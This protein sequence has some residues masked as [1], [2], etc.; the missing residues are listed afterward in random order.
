MRQYEEGFCLTARWARQPHQSL[1]HV[2]PCDMD[3]AEAM[4]IFFFKQKTAYGRR[5]SDWSSDVCSS[6]LMPRE[7]AR[8]KAKAPAVL[9]RRTPYVAAASGTNRLLIGP[10]DSLSAARDV[11][12]RLSGVGISTFPWTSPAGEDVDKLAGK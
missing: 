2:A 6:D 1:H 9:A 3:R 12:N 5:I 11:V 7:W 8:L 10:F 4:D